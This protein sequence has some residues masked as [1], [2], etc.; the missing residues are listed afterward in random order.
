MRNLKREC[1]L[2]RTDDGKAFFKDA[3]DVFKKNIIILSFILFLNLT[4]KN[5]SE[6]GE[7]NIKTKPSTGSA[8]QIL[9][10]YQALAGDT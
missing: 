6:T 8:D 5:L 1:S 10:F 9:A 4:M 2:T 7:S 3:E